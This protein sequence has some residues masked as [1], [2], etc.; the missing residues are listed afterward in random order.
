LEWAEG[1]VGVDVPEL[2]AAEVVSVVERQGMQRAVI[3]SARL[4]K[5]S[6]LVQKLCARLEEHSLVVG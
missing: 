1:G 4:E 2:R 6:G 3:R 5:V